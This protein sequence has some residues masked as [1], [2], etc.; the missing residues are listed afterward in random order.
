MVRSKLTATNKKLF[1]KGLALWRITAGSILDV[2]GMG[3]GTMVEMAEIQVR[4]EKCTEQGF[5]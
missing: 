1:E 3:I 2:D 5:I 4:D